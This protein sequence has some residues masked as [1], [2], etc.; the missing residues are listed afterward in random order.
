M[1]L[2]CWSVF[3]SETNTPSVVLQREGEAR[4]WALDFDYQ[5]QMI[6]WIEHN[7]SRILRMHISGRDV[8]VSVTMTNE[9]E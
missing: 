6:Y 4:M 2:T 9:D 8:Q 5:Q 3:L 1:L 7:P